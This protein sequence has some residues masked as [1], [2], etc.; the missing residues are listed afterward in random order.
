MF[1]A[2]SLRELHVDHLPLQVNMSLI[3]N[4]CRACHGCDPKPAGKLSDVGI[5]GL[6]IY[7]IL[8]V[9]SL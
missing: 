8:R 5:P 3:P 9:V 1:L 7:Y 2:E 6:A 4:S